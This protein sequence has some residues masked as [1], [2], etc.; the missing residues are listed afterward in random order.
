MKLWLRGFEIFQSLDGLDVGRTHAPQIWNRGRGYSWEDHDN[1]PDFC[2]LGG[3]GIDPTIVIGGRQ[4]PFPPMPGL[5][6]VSTWLLKLMRAMQFSKLVPTIGVV[7]N[8][9][10]AFRSLAGGI[11]EIEDA[12]ITPVNKVPF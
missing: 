5:E 4:N 9:D 10:E 2:G 8:I 7:T 12:F 1:I 11:A 6:P 3:G